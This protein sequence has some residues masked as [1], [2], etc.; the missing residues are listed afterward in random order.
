[1]SQ[2]PASRADWSSL[3]DDILVKAYLRGETAAF[4]VLFK[5][6]RQMVSRLSFSIVRNAALADDVV[7]DVFI[8][9]H[10]HLPKFRWDSAFKTWLYRVTVNEALRH[11]DRTRR[12]T[13]L[14]D[15]G[16]PVN[17]ASALV[18]YNVGD[19]PE[20]MLMESEQQA[21]VQRALGSLRAPHRVILNLYYLEEMSVQEVAKVL[22]IPEG[23]VK[24]RLFYARDALK[25]ALQPVLGG[26]APGLE[27]K[28]HEAR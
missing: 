26:A 19:S 4:E 15:D 16:P 11:L 23:S 9:V 24:S 7:Q 21:L 20:R 25:N 27:K 14:P 5:K 3:D 17:P 12:W 10:R 22:E 6:Y 18:A 2:L 13:Q 28:S 1:M 8:L